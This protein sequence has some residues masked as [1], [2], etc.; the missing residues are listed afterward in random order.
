MAYIISTYN[1]YDQ[2]NREHARYKFEINGI[3]YAV[4][5]VEMDWGVPKLPFYTDRNESAYEYHIY[6]TYE[7]AM[8][9]VW[10]IKSRHAR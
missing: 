9:F 3:W 10:E 4:F 1:K 7:D 8:K 5:E 2:W 6:D